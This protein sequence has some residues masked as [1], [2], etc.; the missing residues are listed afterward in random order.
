MVVSSG[1]MTVRRDDELAAAARAGDPGALREVVDRYGVSVFDFIVRATGQ[2]EIGADLTRRVFDSPPNES[3]SVRADLFARAKRLIG[4]TQ[5]V[6]EPPAAWGEIS[7]GPTFEEDEAARTRLEA[8]QVWDA[9]RA[10]DIATYMT[11]D[12]DTQRGLSSEELAAVLGVSRGHAAIAASRAREVVRT[13]V[14]T[15]LLVERGECEAIEAA[16]GSPEMVQRHVMRCSS[17]QEAK[18]TMRLPGLAMPVFVSLQPPAALVAGLVVEPVVSVTAPTGRSRV[19]AATVAVGIVA[20]VAVGAAAAPLVMNVND[21][22]ETTI[23]TTS[24]LRDAVPAPPPTNIVSAAPIPVVADTTTTS[25][26]ALRAT[27][28]SYPFVSF[29]YPSSPTATTTASTTTTSTTTTSATSTTSAPAK[30]TTTTVAT[31]TTTV[32]VSTTTTT[33]P[34][35]TT[36]TKPPPT[37]TTTKPPNEA[38]VATIAWPLPD[39]KFCEFQ[40]VNFSGSATD[41][42]GDG[43]SGYAWSSSINGTFGSAATAQAVLSPGFHTITFTAT[44]AKGA[45]GS[46]SISIQVRASSAP[47]C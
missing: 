33:A 10:L 23:V 39:G 45:S 18:S 17:C 6:S 25:T 22:I 44:D 8:Q 3:P 37:T 32:A 16:T 1:V 24:T 30:T 38:P 41:A 11:F 9:A 4:E 34:T 40:T 47:S 35:T 43:I 7:V 5:R 20:L 2:F 14:A 31:T 46:I 27:T 12:L 15:R 26:T 13:H 19:L 28:T 29:P 21:P 42:D 36:T